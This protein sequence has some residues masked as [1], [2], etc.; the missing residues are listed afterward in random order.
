M[1]ENKYLNA[2]KKPYKNIYIDFSY[3]FYIQN[4][5]INLYLHI[6]IKFHF[7]KTVNMHCI[8]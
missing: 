1:N 5:I 6:M 3:Y 8:V 4:L 2:I 7:R